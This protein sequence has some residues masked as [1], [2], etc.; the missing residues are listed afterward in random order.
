[1]MKMRMKIKREK[2]SEKTKK[3]EYTPKFNVR[4]GLHFQHQKKW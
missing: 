4:S 2:K 1:M 3:E